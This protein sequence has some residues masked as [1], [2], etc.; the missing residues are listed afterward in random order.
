MFLSSR[1]RH[2]RCALVTGVQTCALPIYSQ[3]SIMPMNRVQFQPSLSLPEFVRR[4]GTQGA[5]E[6]ALRD[7]RWPAGFVCP[8]CQGASASQFRRFDQPYW[9]CSA[10]HHQ[11]SLLAGTVFASTK[12]PLTTW[13]LALYLLSQSKNAIAA[14]ELSRHLV[15]CYSTAWRIKHKLMT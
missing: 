13:F 3:V 4:Y 2:T 15:V 8:H 7:A 1:R 11:T 10:C 14:L 6:H 12:L 5:C 9:Q